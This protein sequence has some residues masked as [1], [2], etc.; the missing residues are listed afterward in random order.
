[1]NVYNSNSKIN[2]KK[3]QML[4]FHVLNNEDI[5]DPTEYNLE[6]KTALNLIKNKDYNS[7]LKIFEE[8]I[9]NIPPNELL[10]R[11]SFYLGEIYYI[12]ADFYKSYIYLL[13]S[14]D[15]YKNESQPF[16]TSIELNIF[17]KLE[18]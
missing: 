11:I 13:Y 9:N 12:K 10:E 16:L 1:M 7:A 5:F 6:Y 4:N 8:M 15:K 3:M 18:R 2:Q 17:S 14:N